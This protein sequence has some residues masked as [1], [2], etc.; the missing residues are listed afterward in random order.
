MSPFVQERSERASLPDKQA[1]RLRVVCPWDHGN[2][3]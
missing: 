2:R 1:F 3:S